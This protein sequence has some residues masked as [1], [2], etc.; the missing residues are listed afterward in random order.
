VTSAIPQRTLI[1]LPFPGQAGLIDALLDT[2]LADVR[3]PATS[4][5]LLDLSG[6]MKGDRIAG[7]KQAMRILAS[8]SADPAERY[9]KFQ[10]REEVGIITFSSEPAPTRMFSMGST[11]EQNAKTRSD[12]AAFVNSLEAGGSTAI[13]ASIQQA[14]NELAGG[15]AKNT[16]K[17]YYTVVLMTDGENNR[18][19]TPAGFR[20]WYESQG[21]RVRGIRVFPILFGE[22]DQSELSGIADLTGGRLFD[23][24]SRSLAA[25]FK[26]IRGYQ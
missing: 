7:L 19:L 26:E 8:N 20:A 2:F 15:R 13:Y 12:I 10:R 4:R 16:D 3:I 5:Y 25:A 9:A 11:P 1:E 17:R 22:G 21:D 6:S 18:G 14:L 23:S 24:K